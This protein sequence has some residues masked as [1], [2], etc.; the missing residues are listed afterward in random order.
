MNFRTLD[1]NLLRVFDAV[2]QERHV[3][4]AAVLLAMTQ[5]AV[6]NALRRLRDATGE[7]LFVPGPTGVTP[8]PRAQALW[9]TVREALAS[10]RE[11]LDPQ[12]FDPRRN[13][14][15]FT[16]SMADA[17][18]TVLLPALMKHVQSERL[19]VRLRA[20]P[21]T[22]R[23]P[24]A[25]LERGGAELAVGF[26]PE[27]LRAL[28]AAGDQADLVHAPLYASR[29]VCVMRR[30]HPLARRPVLSLDDYAGAEHLRVNFA[31]RHHGFVDEALAGL[32]RRRRVALTLGHFSGVAETLQQ[33]DLVAVL[34]L[35]YVAAA[36]ATPPLAVRDLPLPL[37]VKRVDML[38]HRRHAG[39]PGHRW[40]RQT[41]ITAAST[42]ALSM[43]RTVTAKR[44]KGTT[45]MRSPR[46]V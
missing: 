42:V 28:A 33:S 1:L 14:R 37:P 35:C 16:L 8:T 6:S 19:A 38:W 29:F 21:L 43:D 10:V 7:D 27:V 4:R 39:D 17:T 11:L 45:A 3:T 32:G 13:D 40:L 2:M 5:P 24:R 26:F 23:D 31:G 36:G 25:Q 20:E 15:V 9:P 34:P 18:A 22:T 12:A 46:R 44:G 41:L 30:G